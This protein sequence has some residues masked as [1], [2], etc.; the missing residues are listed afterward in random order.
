MVNPNLGHDEPTLG[1]G[2]ARAGRELIQKTI[3]SVQT[4]FLMSKSVIHKLP[5]RKV[6]FGPYIF[7]M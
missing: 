3:I 7:P 4:S 5:K 6:K 2:T 1:V